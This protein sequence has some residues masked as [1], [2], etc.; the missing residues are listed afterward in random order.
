MREKISE[1]LFLTHIFSHINATMDIALP[2]PRNINAGNKN[3]R[4]SIKIGKL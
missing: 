1:E 2:I 4:I 3:V